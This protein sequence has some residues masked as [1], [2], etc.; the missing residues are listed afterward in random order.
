[1]HERS[2]SHLCLSSSHHLHLTVVGNPLSPPLVKE[3]LDLAAPCHSEDSLKWLDG[4]IR[5]VPLVDAF[6]EFFP[7]SE[8]RFT[9]WDQYTNRR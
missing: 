3:L 8:G 7:L 6:A 9:C 1:M 5:E 4:V 2:L